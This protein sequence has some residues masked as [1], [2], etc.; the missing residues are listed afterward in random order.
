MS[1]YIINKRLRRL[2]L[3]SVYFL[4]LGFAAVP[5]PAAHSPAA[6][7]NCGGR[8]Y[9]V[10]VAGTVRQPRCHPPATAE[11]QQLI[12]PDNSAGR[13]AARPADRLRRR[14]S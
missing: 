7:R 10:R 1:I 3:Q 4:I 6:G 11:R 5:E 9:A 12:G 2:L 13:S 14:V 8:S